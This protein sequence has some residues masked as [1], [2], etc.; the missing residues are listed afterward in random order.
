MIFFNTDAQMD[1]QTHKLNTK[2]ITPL[3]YP[4]TGRI[5]YTPLLLPLTHSIL[6]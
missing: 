4:G 5:F 3:P 6:F 2:Q 1:G